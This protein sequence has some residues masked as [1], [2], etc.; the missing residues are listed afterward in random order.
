MAYATQDAVG[1]IFRENS[2]GGHPVAAA[3]KIYAQTITGGT[4]ANNDARPYQ[5]GDAILGISQEQIDNTAGVAGARTVRVR[6]GCA[7]L[8]QNG[9][10]TRAHI[11]KFAKAL[12]DSTV[13]IEVAPDTATVN[14]IGT[15]VDVESAATVW[16]EVRRFK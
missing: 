7:R 5:V 6:R 8:A 10:I 14:T 15:I 12:D 4:G 1:V 9:T 11:N 3:T 13:A 2:E 16:I